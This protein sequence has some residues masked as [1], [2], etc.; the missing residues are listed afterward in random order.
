MRLARKLELFAV[1]VRGAFRIGRKRKRYETEDLESQR[2][3]TQVS[4]GGEQLAKN[5]ETLHIENCHRSQQRGRGSFRT[6]TGAP[7]GKVA[8][9]S[10]NKKF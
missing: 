7:F 9:V 6:Q 5:V 4:D 2:P 1:H 8:M 3:L 10:G